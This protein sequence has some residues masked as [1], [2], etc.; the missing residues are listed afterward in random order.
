MSMISLVVFLLTVVFVAYTSQ[1]LIG[2]LLLAG[3]S[4]FEIAKFGMQHAPFLVLCEITL[5]IFVVKETSIKKDKSPLL[6]YNPFYGRNKLNP[7]IRLVILIIFPFA[8]FV[9]L[10]SFF[11]WGR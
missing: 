8:L 9:R 7:K 10:F 5:A 4:L 3:L 2:I 11:V 1:Y 6:A